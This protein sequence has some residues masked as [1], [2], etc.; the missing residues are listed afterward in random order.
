MSL[1]DSSAQKMLTQSVKFN[2]SIVYINENAGEAIST[3][4]K[5]MNC[6]N[7]EQQFSIVFMINNMATRRSMKFYFIN[8]KFD[9]F[10]C[11][12]LH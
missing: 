7:K 9:L 6:K 5:E 8:N 1:T 2:H 10:I 12:V 3:F 4:P 11:L